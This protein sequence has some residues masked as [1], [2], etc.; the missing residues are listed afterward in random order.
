MPQI[1]GSVCVRTVDMARL[2]SAFPSNVKLWRLRHGVRV[3]PT[4]QQTHN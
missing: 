3:D 1:S 4:P 2:I